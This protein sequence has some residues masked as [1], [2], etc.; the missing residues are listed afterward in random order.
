MARVK[1]MKCLPEGRNLGGTAE[2]FVPCM[3]ACRGFFNAQWRAGRAAS[4]E[5]LL[6]S[7]SKK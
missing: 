3:E 4:S 1:R 5:K 6:Y 7:I 2:K